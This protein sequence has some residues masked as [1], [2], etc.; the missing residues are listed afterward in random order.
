MNPEIERIIGR[1]VTDI[2][3]R[4]ELINDPEGTI[5]KYGYSLTDDEIDEFAKTVRKNS[6][7]KDKFN[8]SLRGVW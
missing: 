8:D 1:A 6:K 4:E 2:D 7:D 3:F 5:R